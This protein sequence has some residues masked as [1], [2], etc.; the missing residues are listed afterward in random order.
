[1]NIWATI[2]ILAAEK[3]GIPLARHVGGWLIDWAG[4]K[5]TEVMVKKANL[6]PATPTPPATTGAA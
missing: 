1:M 3:I 4:K 6:P 5:A 2:G